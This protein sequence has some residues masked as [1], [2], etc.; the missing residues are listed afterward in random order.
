VAGHFGRDIF[1]W[2]QADKATALQ[3]ALN[4]EARNVA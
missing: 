3:A 1:P 4:I 2:E